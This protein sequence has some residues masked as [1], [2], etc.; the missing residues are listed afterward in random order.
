M[1]MP[2]QQP[3][4]SKQ[5]YRT[6][7][8]F[9]LAAKAFL[10][11]GDFVID[12]AAEAENAVCDLYYDVATNSLE[13]PWANI[14]GIVPT[15]NDWNWLNPEYA[16]IE[17]WVRKAYGAMQFGGNTAVLIPLSSSIWWHRWVHG[18]AHVLLL[19]GEN[20]SGRLCFIPDWETTI[21]PASEKPG[22]TPRCYTS[23]PL[24]P[25]D[26]ALL[27]YGQPERFPPA[28][29]TWDW[30]ADYEKLSGRALDWRKR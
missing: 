15:E 27:L 8:E 26:C 29:D 19:G 3:G 17:P 22:K 18:K 5:N 11:I 14:P 21:D 7:P 9:L 16:D 25:K 13:Q 4:K 6:P 12:L 10:G 30:V 1:P 2:A 23:P 24:Y 20:H 28:Y